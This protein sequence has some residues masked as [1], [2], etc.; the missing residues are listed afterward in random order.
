[1]IVSVCRDLS[2]RAISCSIRPGKL[3]DIYTELQLGNA[4]ALVNGK[5]APPEL[6]VKESDIVFIRQV[7]GAISG[8]VALFIAGALLIAGASYAGYQLYQQR[9]Q[10]SQLQ[11]AMDELGSVSGA[12]TNLPYLKG[13]NNAKALD[14]AVPYIIGKNYIAPYILSN[15]EIRY[16]SITTRDGPRDVVSRLVPYQVGYN[17]LVL[18]TAYANGNVIHQ[19]TGDVPQEGTI[20]INGQSRLVIS[21]SGLDGL[22]AY[23]DTRI[24]LEP[25]DRLLK[26]DDPQYAPLVYTLPTN[27]R[28]TTVTLVFNGLLKYS[29]KGE[30]QSHSLVIHA[31]YSDDGGAT[32]AVFPV[33][34]GTITANTKTQMRVERTIT[35]YYRGVKDLTV[36]IQIKI[37]CASNAFDGSAL[38]DV[39]V[40]TLESLLYD[41][42]ASKAANAFVNLPILDEAVADKSCLV[43]YTAMARNSSEEE[44]FQNFALIV[45]GVASTWDGTEW[46]ATKAPTSNPAAWLIEILTSSVHPQSQIAI[47]D[48]DLDSFGELYEYCEA[49]DIKFDKVYLSGE[50]KENI[51]QSI[52]DVCYSTLYKNIDG[53]IAVATDKQKE[54]AIAV[55]NTQNC[56]SFSNKKDLSRPVDGLR[57]SFVNEALGYEQDT[58]EVMRPGITKDANS[59]IRSITAD[60]ITRYS[61]VVKWAWR[62]MAIE[63]ARPK[64]T[65]VEIGNEGVYYT[66]LS[67]VLVQHPSLKNGLGSAEI[68]N[69]VVSGGNIIGLDLYEPIAFDSSD[70]D[71]YGMIVQCVSDDYCTPLAIEYTGVDG[72][73]F[74]VALVTPISTTADVIPHAGDTLSYGLLDSGSFGTITNPMMIAGMSQTERGWKLELVDYNEAIYEYGAIP[75]YKPNITKKTV[76]AYIPEEPRPATVEDVSKAVALITSD[77]SPTWIPDTVDGVTASAQRDTITIAWPWNGSAINNIVKNFIVEIEKGDDEWI[78]LTPVTTNRAVYTFDRNT[79]GYP[80]AVDL[81]DWHVRVKAVN[82]YGNASAA[83]GPS[84]VGQVVDLTEY[85]TWIPSVPVVSPYCNGREAVLSWGA[86]AQYGRLGYQVQIARKDTVPDEEDWEK[87]VLT[88]DPRASEENYSDGTTGTLFTTVEQISQSLPLHNQALGLPVDTK[89]YYR[90]RGVT[91]V[92]T[93]ADPDA[94]ILGSWSGAYPVLARPTGTMDL[95]EKAIK[96]AQLD[97]DAVTVEKLNVL[98]KNLV[99]PFTSEALDAM[100]QGWT[101]TGLSVCKIA[102]SSEIGYNVLQIKSTADGSGHVVSDEF[103][104]GP[105][106]I[107]ELTVALMSDVAANVSVRP[108]APGDAA[109]QTYRSAWDATNKAWGAFGNLTSGQL[110]IENVSPA[111]A[112]T[113]YKTY[114]VGSLVDPSQI[115]APINVQY[116]VRMVAG[117][118][119]MR[120]HVVSY[121]AAATVCVGIPTLQKLGAGQLTANQILVRDLS[122]IS[123]NVGKLEGDDPDAFTLVGNNGYDKPLGTFLLGK[124]TDASYLRRWYDTAT[125]TWKMAIKL[126]TFFV[127]AVTSKILGR[128]QVRNAADTAT[129]LDV[130]PSNPVAVAV[131]GGMSVSG[132]LSIDGGTAWHSLND[133]AG[134]GLDADTVD[135]I[136]GSHILHV[137]GGYLSTDID[138]LTSEGVY[139]IL[140]AGRGYS[141]MLVFGT[142]T[143][144]STSTV[145][146]ETSWSPGAL[147]TGCMRFRNKTDSNTWSG[148]KTIWT[149]HNDGAGSGLDADTLDG[150]H[151]NDFV[152]FVNLY[153]NGRTGY[154]V[155]RMPNDE[156]LLIQWALISTNGASGAYNH[157]IIFPASF[158]N[159]NYSFV[160]NY[161]T[162][163][164]PT[165]TNYMYGNAR[166]DTKTASTITV[167]AYGGNMIAYTAIGWMN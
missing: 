122:A 120:I 132:G 76:H 140:Y 67:K 158:G 123:A 126:A 134:S 124:A 45:E 137:I 162:E 114:L 92:P 60:G 115:P 57:V 107:L 96:T 118:T 17:K 159:T 146:L 164:A 22:T 104:V 78:A 26:L 30:A 7:P 90:V 14:H 97:D 20:V 167:K 138:Y 128:F 82:I 43:G 16:Y 19:F 149:D 151:A 156:Y 100:P 93:S 15:G 153:R 71:R 99:N 161:Q 36:P 88:L 106:D 3:V 144:G 77:G 166:N 152:K 62:L 91:A 5:L 18:R 53:K 74:S 75:E 24:L 33:D 130:D 154:V 28:Q 2:D 69:V 10:L 55:I 50:P 6:E 86:G 66:P 11:E 105:Y 102:A 110:L 42:V 63:S 12:V 89:Y 101:A 131:A 37:S 54:N 136:Q 1:M 125:S 121:L 103:T 35:F 39:Y 129:T 32:W 21:Q 142:I 163:D 117:Q 23:R 143:G 58:Y 111:G 150:L 4:V 87:P 25:G 160:A 119:A 108:G 68:K 127:D 47:E 44:A 52:C 147:F 141:T 8:G 94:V 81:T 9:K 34:F 41:P 155:M 51:I 31:Y 79:D 61:Q 139:S 59:R 135:G 64:V 148:W 113:A 85:L 95:V 48:I 65:T 46:S 145:Q 49:E 133:G 165:N 157:S 70:A 84:D 13:A 27:A 80:E 98:A 112:Y 29:K 38:E 116:C 56:F 83:Y 40:Q 72:L 109:Y 73:N